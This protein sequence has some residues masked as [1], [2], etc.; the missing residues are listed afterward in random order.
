[1]IIKY[2]LDLKI[3]IEECRNDMYELANKKG[4][5]NPEVLKIS[6]ELDKKI[7]TMQNLLLS[8]YSQYR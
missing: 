6:Q 8:L 2:A 7:I 1:M 4:I 5:N 3:N